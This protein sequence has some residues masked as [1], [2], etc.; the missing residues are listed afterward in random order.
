MK[1]PL[2]KTLIGLAISAFFVWL[3][4][5]GKD[6]SLMWQSMR[7]VSRLG[8]IGYLCMLLLIQAVRSLRW[9]VLIKPLDA[10]LSFRRVNAA[11][12]VGLML[13]VVLPFRLGE[14]ARPL[15]LAE[16]KLSRGSALT[17]SVVVERIVDAVAFALLLLF[18]LPFVQSTSPWL[19]YMRGGGALVFALFGG[20]GSL[21]G[22]AV[23]RRQVALRLV[24]LMLTPLSPGLSQRVLA[25]M[26]AFLDGV[27]VLRSGR[28]KVA[29]ILLTAI[30]VLLNG[31]AIGVLAEGFG[32]PLSGLAMFSILSVCTVGSMIPA[33]PGSLGVAQFFVEVGAGFFVSPAA[34]TGSVPA[35]ANLMWALQWGQQIVLG[36]VMLASGEV[37]RAASQQALQAL[38]RES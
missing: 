2:T 10:T 9:Y 33:G 16:G 32:L 4:L 18:T 1:H 34:M 29:V 21:L 7:G 26:D 14:F 20:L 37:T 13:A 5:R 6:L 30:Y 31:L 11:Y 36:L 12:A 27:H 23:W 22:I 3:S 25:L 15:L 28:A 35:F 19:P 24:G 38:E 17:A 8:L